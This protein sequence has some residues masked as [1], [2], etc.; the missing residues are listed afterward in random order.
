MA[1]R[2]KIRSG[3]L[4]KANL[5]KSRL[6]D[7]RHYFVTR[8]FR[9]GA[10]APTV[11]ALAGHQHPSVTRRCAHTSEVAKRKAVAGLAPWPGPAG[12]LAR[13][14]QRMG[15]GRH[16]GVDRRRQKGQKSKSF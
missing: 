10:D 14:G 15:K 3:N 12:A 9:I 2:K 13:D 7:L 11:Q 16:G 6:H 4:A 8:C 1:V 5:P